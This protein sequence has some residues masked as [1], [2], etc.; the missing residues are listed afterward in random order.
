[1]GTLSEVAGSYHRTDL[2]DW[3]SI[4]SWSLI[5]PWSKACGVGGQPGT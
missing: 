3:E 2:T 5:K 4:F 1:M